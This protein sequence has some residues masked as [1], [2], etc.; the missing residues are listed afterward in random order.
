MDQSTFTLHL[1]RHK[2]LLFYKGV[3]NRV[4]VTSDDSRRLSIPW[5]LL[6]AHMTENGVHGRFQIR[7]DESGKCCGLKPL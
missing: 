6:Q 3:K 7:F 4:L 2:A 5:Q 1:P